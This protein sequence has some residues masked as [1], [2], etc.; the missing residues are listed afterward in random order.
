MMQIHL[1][2]RI[3]VTGAGQRPIHAVRCRR[4]AGMRT[5]RGHVRRLQSANR[6]EREPNRSDAA[7]ETSSSANITR[8]QNASMQ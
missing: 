5:C 4:I 3:H 7:S 8:V 2:A 6:A 1:G